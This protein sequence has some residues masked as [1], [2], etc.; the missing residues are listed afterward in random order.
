MSLTGLD[1]VLEFIN[2]NCSFDFHHLWNLNLL[3]WISL[4]HT[5]VHAHTMTLRY[6]SLFYLLY[7]TQADIFESI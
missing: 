1:N 5:R 3:N 7:N 2:P 4:T 6:Y